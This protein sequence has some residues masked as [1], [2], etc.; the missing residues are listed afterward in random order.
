MAY[1]KRDMET[2]VVGLMKEYSCILITGPRQVG[3]STMLNHIDSSRA[4][5]TLDDLQERELARNDPEMFLKV[6]KPPILIDEVQYAP[7]LFSYLKI[8]IDNGAAPGSYFLTGSQSYKL[9]KLAKESLAGRIAI[10]SLTS[11]SQHE[12][13]ANNNLLPFEVSMDNIQA[14]SNGI[15]SVSIEDVYKRIWEGGLPGLQSGKYTNRDVY[16]SS[17]FQT[18]TSTAME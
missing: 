8:A 11:L 2:L 16:Y 18:S 1:I 14:R 10:L 6:H 17:Y 9:M 12:L 5:V 15:D 4:K 13:Y 3:K 7:E